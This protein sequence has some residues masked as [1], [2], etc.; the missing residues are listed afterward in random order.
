[1]EDNKTGSKLRSSIRQENQDSVSEAHAWYR[2]VGKK[3][4][5]DGHDPLRQSEA[6]STPS[7]A[8]RFT[9]K[10]HSNNVGDETSNGK[11]QRGSNDRHGNARGSRKKMGSSDAFEG[12]Y[13][14]TAKRTAR[15]K[16]SANVSRSLNQIDT[17]PRIGASQSDN[18]EKGYREVAKHNARNKASQSENRPLS[19]SATTSRINHQSMQGSANGSRT[20]SEISS[21]R[22]SRVRGSAEDMQR[23]VKEARKQTSDSSQSLRRPKVHGEMASLRPSSR[24]DSLDE[25]T[26]S[27]DEPRVTSRTKSR[28]ASFHDSLRGSSRHDNL[29]K[30]ATSRY[31]PR[32]TPRTKSR[33]ASSHDS[34]RLSSTLRHASLDKSATSRYEPRVTPR[35]KSRP[36]SSHDSL[37]LSSTLRH[38][39]LDK[40]ATSRYEPRVT[41]R[42]KTGPASFTASTPNQSAIG[43]TERHSKSMLVAKG[44]DMA[45]LR[46]STTR[47]DDELTDVRQAIRKRRDEDFADQRR[48]VKHPVT[49]RH[50]PRDISEQRGMFL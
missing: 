9:P 40:S 48:A 46:K 4:N 36:A 47:G 27:R 33:P 44:S 7:N 14:E 10:K 23:L 17:Q 5:T 29:D 38:A 11:H 6:A 39:S 24:H 2:P 32:V 41:S 18:F 13:R 31:E 28:P 16:A 12:G 43:R 37:R 20:N 25:S 49:R 35:T 15:K 42:T 1:V 8:D 22:Q 26:T 50:R 34:L 21:L 45:A 19:Q 3:Q 30:S